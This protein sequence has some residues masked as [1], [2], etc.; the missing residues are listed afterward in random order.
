VI[1]IKNLHGRKIILKSGDFVYGN[2]DANA[3]AKSLEILLFI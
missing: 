2:K 3:W 1:N